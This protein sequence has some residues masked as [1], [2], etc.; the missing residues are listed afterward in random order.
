MTKRRQDVRAIPFLRVEGFEEIGGER[1]K[2]WIDIK[3]AIY[4]DVRLDSTKEPFETWWL[5]T[6]H[7]IGSFPNLGKKLIGYYQKLIGCRDL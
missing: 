2:T 5:S 7:R 3:V 4:L 1:K 6:Q